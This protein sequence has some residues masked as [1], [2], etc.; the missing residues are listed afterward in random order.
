MNVFFLCY[1][2]KLLNH[3]VPNNVGV[4]AYNILSALLSWIMYK[5]EQT[6]MNN[7]KI[8]HL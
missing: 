3:N 6:T 7:L 1:I 5:S 4:Y 2:K 8:S